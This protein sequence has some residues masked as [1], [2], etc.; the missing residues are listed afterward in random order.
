M[1]VSEVEVNYKADLTKLVERSSKLFTL[2]MGYDLDYKEDHKR[3]YEL[4]AELRSKISSLCRK[5]LTVK[6]PNPP[7]KNEE[8]LSLKKINNGLRKDLKDAK[9]QIHLLQRIGKRIIGEKTRLMQKQS[10]LVRRI[11]H[12]NKQVWTN[13]KSLKKEHEQHLKSILDEL[14]IQL[15]LDRDSKNSQNLSSWL[16]D[17]EI[18][19][20]MP[21]AIKAVK[22]LKNQLTNVLQDREYQLKLKDSIIQQ[23]DAEIQEKTRILEERDVTIRDNQQT[24]CDKNMRIEQHRRTIHNKSSLIQHLRPDI[25]SNDQRI[26][27]LESRITDKDESI[28]E[29]R[30]SLAE[31]EESLRQLRSNLDKNNRQIQGLESNLAENFQRVEELK[32]SL[33]AKDQSL[34]Q[35]QAR[36]IVKGRRIK[37][38][39]KDL[40]GEKLSLEEAK[41]IIEE[42]DS[43]IQGLK[44]ENHVKA[45]KILKIESTIVNLNSVIER[46]ELVIQETENRM[47]QRCLEL[48]TNSES[49]LKKLKDQIQILNKKLSEKN[50]KKASA[51]NYNSTFNVSSERASTRKKDRLF[52][53]Y[54]NPRS[55]REKSNLSLEDKLKKLNKKG[56][57]VN[58]ISGISESSYSINPFEESLLPGKGVTRVH[59]SQ[60]KILR[61]AVKQLYRVQGRD[62]LLTGNLTHVAFKDAKNFI[63]S[64]ER[65]GLVIIEGGKRILYS[66][67]LPEQSKW[68]RDIVYCSTLDCYFLDHANKLYRKDI[69]KR[70]AYEYMKIKCGARPGGCFYYSEIQQRLIIAR[71]SKKITVVNLML[72]DVEFD[73]EKTCGDKIKDFK[74]FGSLDKKVV[75]ITSNGVV[76]RYNLD[77]VNWEGIVVETHKLPLDKEIN[78]RAEAIALCPKHKYICVEVGR[79]T[80]GHICSKMTIL[81]LK[82]NLL[83]RK[84]TVNLNYTGIGYKMAL[85]CYGYHNGTVLFLGLSKDEGYVQVYEYNF[86][87]DRLR[88]LYQHRIPHQEVGPVRIHK[89]RD[90]YYYT[91]KNGKIMKLTLK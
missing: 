87:E 57:Q 39:I 65:K 53:S 32:S 31:K 8:I 11:N 41:K 43:L 26:R 48:K 25:L 38:L 61:L 42:R 18:K 73:A 86:K 37:E 50:S 51:I 75:S 79:L 76:L 14:L 4:A 21:M 1:E 19:I 49:E 45:S 74:V 46:K 35:L 33:D 2:M 81:K 55:Y 52:N 59:R 63:I 82:N 7:K 69:D 22:D 27:Q 28:R 84:T 85:T 66:G 58:N 13:F 15:D 6:I 29:L 17:T 89:L 47:T 80:G 30:S 88:E 24:I 67:K 78:E 90:D 62:H 12:S 5:H 36:N 10:S 23:K 70:P 44:D 20:I 34:Q 3:I 68:L 60:Q 77:Y 40:N 56:L 54:M 9:T 71:N 91:G 83:T 16:L 72:K 64:T